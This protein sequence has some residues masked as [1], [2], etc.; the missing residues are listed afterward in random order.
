MPIVNVLSGNKESITHVTNL[1]TS[2]WT[3]TAAPFTQTLTINGVLPTSNGIIGLPTTATEAQWSA[4]EEASLRITTVGTNSITITAR[5]K[6][7]I[8]DIPVELIIIP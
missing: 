5:K 3:G 8:I 6:K 1:T 7:P 4:A 2:D